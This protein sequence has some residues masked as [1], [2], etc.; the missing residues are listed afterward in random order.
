MYSYPVSFPSDKVTLCVVHQRP[1]FR[2]AIQYD[3]QNNAPDAEV[4]RQRGHWIFPQL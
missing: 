4:I 3:W 1:L 2:A